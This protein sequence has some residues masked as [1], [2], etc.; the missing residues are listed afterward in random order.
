MNSDNVVTV[1]GC[2]Y[3]CPICMD[4]VDR[5]KNCIV[6]ECGHC[7]HAKCMMTNVQCNG[8][9]CPICRHAMVEEEEEEEDEYDE[10]YEEEDEED[11][12]ELNDYTL[13][14]MRWLFQRAEGEEP[15]D[16]E[17]DY[18]L[19]ESESPARRLPSSDL[20]TRKLVESGFTMEQLVQ[21][22]LLDSFSE[23]DSREDEFSS[24]S[25]DI[26][27]RIK[28]IIDNPPDEELEEEVRAK[29]EAEDER[30]FALKKAEEEVREAEDA[31]NEM[32]YKVR[33]ATKRAFGDCLYFEIQKLHPERAGK[34]TGMILEMDLVW[35]K[36][37]LA[38][39]DALDNKISEAVTIL[40]NYEQKEEDMAEEEALAEEEAITECEAIEQAVAEKEDSVEEKTVEEE[41]EEEE[42]EDDDDRYLDLFD[43]DDVVEEWVDTDEFNWAW[44]HRYEGGLTGIDV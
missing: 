12:E 34:I 8:F 29:R 13:R 23:Y 32:E 7:F 37:L 40:D 39:R 27:H 9:G 41:E 14:G 36:H 22:F 17:E 18:D 3:E 44:D 11:E 10:E 16:F 42:E 21:V 24:T 28:R 5:R 31:R 30:V 6:T 43:M 1:E 2:E 15:D 33:E 38:N 26:Y 4:E 35:L 20:I 19:Q 25:N